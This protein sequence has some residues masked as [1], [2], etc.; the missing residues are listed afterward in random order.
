MHPCIVVQKIPR[1]SFPLSFSNLPLISYILSLY[2]SPSFLLT[3]EHS[4][5]QSSAKHSCRTSI[6]C[7]V[8]EAERRPFSSSTPNDSHPSLNL[9]CH[10]NKFIL[11]KLSS[12]YKLFNTCFHYTTSGRCTLFYTTLIAALC[13]ILKPL[14]RQKIETSDK[15]KQL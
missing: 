1:S 3:Y 4:K 9:L 10:S 15:T 14:T 8:L 6:D 13:S 2:C 12:P 5:V 11:N 7:S